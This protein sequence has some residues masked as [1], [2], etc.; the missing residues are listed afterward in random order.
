LFFNYASLSDSSSINNLEP[1][2][3]LD[4]DTGHGPKSNKLN[5][6]Q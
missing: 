3:E 4:I 6:L 2:H 1:F 5:K